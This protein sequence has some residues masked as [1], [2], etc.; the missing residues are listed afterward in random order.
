MHRDSLGLLDCLLHVVTLLF[1]YISRE[2]SELVE[3][4]AIHERNPGLQVNALV[5]L[6][7]D[8]NLRVL[9]VHFIHDPVP[10]HLRLAYIEA[11]EQL[12]SLLGLFDHD[13]FLGLEGL[14]KLVELLLSC[15]FLGCGLI[16]RKVKERANFLPNCN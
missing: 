7:I 16:F 9:C 12:V 10:L 8:A 4:D 2:D 14:V 3:L 11:T 15:S 6:A 1:S 13:G 5:G